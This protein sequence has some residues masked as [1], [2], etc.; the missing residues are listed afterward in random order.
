MEAV[1]KLV[2]PLRNDP[3]V[4]LLVGAY[5][6]GK[7]RVWLRAAAALGE[8][9]WVGK[10]RRKVVECLGWD[11]RQMGALAAKPE[12]ARIHVVPMGWLAANRLGQ[13]LKKLREQ[14]A[15]DS[16][17]AAQSQSNSKR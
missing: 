14:Y 10:A 7:E 12:Q 8:K 5:T 9:V 11:A 2:E 15:G 13:R 16:E 4:L 17:S 3:E 6:I 1:A